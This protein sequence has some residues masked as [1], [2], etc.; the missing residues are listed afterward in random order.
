MPMPTDSRGRLHELFALDE[1]RERGELSDAELAQFAEM[2]DNLF[3]DAGRTPMARELTEAIQLADILKADGASLGAEEYASVVV[4]FFQ[5]G[6]D[7]IALFSA[8]K[9]IQ[10]THAR[11]SEVP[12]STERPNLSAQDST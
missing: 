4:A 10:R 1:R 6:R 7:R 3:R 11:L 9:S 2:R 8:M 5:A 12:G